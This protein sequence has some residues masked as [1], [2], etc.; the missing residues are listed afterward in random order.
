MTSLRVGLGSPAGTV[1]DDRPTG[2]CQEIGRCLDG[3]SEREM[4][5]AARPD[6]R[7]RQLEVGAGVDE[8]PCVLVAEAEKTELLE[9]PADDPL[10]LDRQVIGL[11]WMFR[12][13]HTCCNERDPSEFVDRR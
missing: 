2:C 3:D 9:P 10:V 5:R 8:H 13:R 4:E 11:W 1:D 7:S 6:E 12:R